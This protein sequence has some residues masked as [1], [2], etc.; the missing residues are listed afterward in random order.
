MSYA[1]VNI[2]HVSATAVMVEAAPAAGPPPVHVRLDS[3]GTIYVCNLAT[4]AGPPLIVRHIRTAGST[5]QALTANIKMVEVVREIESLQQLQP[6]WDGDGAPAPSPEAI[7]RALEVVARVHRLP[8]DVDPDAVGGI[9]LWFY[10]DDGRMV[11]VGVR[12]DGR[13]AVCSYQ[14]DSHIPAVKTVWDAAS[15]AVLVRASIG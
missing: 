6:D 2:S 14:P 7:Q 12:N 1:E 8:D 11:M 10:G 5:E 3:H 15:V 9:A 4:V 13:A